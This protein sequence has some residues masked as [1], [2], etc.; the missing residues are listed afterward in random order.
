MGLIGL[1]SVV[2]V[3]MVVLFVILVV[4]LAIASYTLAQIGNTEDEP[5]YGCD[6]SDSESLKSLHVKL[7]WTVSLSL[8]GAILV[9]IAGVGLAVLGFASSEVLIPVAIATA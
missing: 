4:I 3:G 1:I 8:I 5:D 7:A 6:W 2:A 9:V